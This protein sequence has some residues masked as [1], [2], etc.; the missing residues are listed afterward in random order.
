MRIAY[1][2]PRL[3]SGGSISMVWSRSRSLELIP[4]YPES[5]T[6]SGT[7]TEAQRNPRFFPAGGAC[8]RVPQ[9][10]LTW[11]ASRIAAVTRLRIGEAHLICFRL[12][13]S[14]LN[15]RRTG[16]AIG[17]DQD[18]LLHRALIQNMNRS[19]VCRSCSDTKTRVFSDRRRL[20]CL[21][22]HDSLP[23]PVLFLRASMAAATLA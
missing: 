13:A 3:P 14:L 4:K 21:S 22:A 17:S 9:S 7:Y 20:S 6:K 18:P 19:A 15:S 16:E 2:P 12:E 5:V 1:P 10:V 11:P 23:C 8:S